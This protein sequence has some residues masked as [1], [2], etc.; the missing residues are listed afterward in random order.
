MRRADSVRGLCIPVRFSGGRKTFRHTE[1]GP[2]QRTAALICKPLPFHYGRKALRLTDSLSVPETEATRS[3]RED[4]A[5]GRQ[6]S[7]L[8]IIPNS[9]KFNSDTGPAKSAGSGS[10]LRG[11]RS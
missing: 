3:G 8:A 11:E 1:R 9:R 7:G 5:W 6:N 10:G 4:Q 2:S